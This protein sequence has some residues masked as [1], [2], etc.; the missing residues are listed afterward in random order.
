ML[1]KARPWYTRA[2]LDCEKKKA[3]PK[4]FLFPCEHIDGNISLL[5]DK[6]FFFFKMLNHVDT[7]SNVEMLSCL[8]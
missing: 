3:L 6:V 1:N 4:R 8:A 5:E 2:L 7:R